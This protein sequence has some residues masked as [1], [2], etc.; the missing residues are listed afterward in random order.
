MSVIK[1]PKVRGTMPTNQE[2]PLLLGP[3][4]DRGCMVQPDGEIIT[5][6]QGGYQSITYAEHRKE[7]ARVASALSKAAG[8]AEGDVVSSFLWNNARHYQLYHAVPSMSAI[9]NTLNLRLSDKEVA[10]IIR[11]AQ[12]KVLVVDEDMLPKIEAVFVVDPALA[13]VVQKVIVCGLD[14]GR[15]NGSSK[16][17]GAVDW[18]VF[19]AAGSPEDFRTWP[20]FSE[21]AACFLCYT[22]GTTGNPKGV[23]YSHRSTYVHVIGQTT[24]DMMNISGSDTLC[25]VVPMFHAAG[26][27]VPLAGLM[28]GCRIVLVNRFMAPAEVADTVIETGVSLSA[29]VPAVWQMLRQALEKDPSKIQRVKGVLKTLICGGSAPPQEMMMWFYNEMGVEFRHIWGMTE[30][31]PMGCTSH[32]VQT[33]RDLNKSPEERA[34]NL[35]AQGIPFN[36]IEWAIA[37]PDHLETRLPHDGE[38]SGELLCKG[39]AVTVS[40]WKGVGADKFIDGYLMTGDVASLTPNNVMQI[41]DRSKDLVKSGGEFISSVD[42]EN[43]LTGMAEIAVACVVAVPHPKWDERPVA[44][45]VPPEG[46]VAPS[47]EEVCKFLAGSSFSKFQWPD[48]IIQW[49]AIPMTGTGKMDK[50]NVR[51]LLKDKG[52]VLPELREPKA[53]L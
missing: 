46:K 5:K 16:L 47:R 9:L 28:L 15:W 39:P 53:K 29:A 27:C 3:L 30:T 49:E 24:P 43:A 32:F 23:A 8:I 21:D 35:K 25:P 11:D 41:R 7:T 31:N 37:D 51:A 10:W 34:S 48:D 45:V 13:Q 1:P 40:Y 52:Y 2:Y 12:T 44:I 26:W 4:L 19:M 17:P 18:N 22:S 33:R 38:T 6:T 42:L 50:K 20:R 14:G 36:A